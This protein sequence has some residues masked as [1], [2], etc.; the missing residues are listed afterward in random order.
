[1]VIRAR[2]ADDVA[3]RIAEALDADLVDE[4]GDLPTAIEQCLRALDGRTQALAALEIHA[5][6]DD[7]AA[8]GA[9][10]ISDV[11]RLRRLVGRI[12]QAEAL[13]E[14]TH[15]VL[16]ERVGSSTGVALHPEALRAAA[17][18]VAAARAAVV[19]LA[20]E[21]GKVEEDLRST[22]D[23]PSMSAL[24]SDGRVVEPDW[25]DDERREA[26]RAVGVFGGALV[27][28]I[29]ALVVLGT[30]VGLLLPVVA[31]VWIGVVF[32]R[33]RS[34]LDDLDV[35]AENLASVT[36]LTDQA[37]GGAV[38]GRTSPELEDLRDQMGKALDR[39]RY[40]DSA[41]VGLVGPDVGIETIDDLL[42]AR[43]PQYDVSDVVLSQTP[44]ARAAQAHVR[45]LTAQWKLAWY[46]LDRPVP[47]L[48][49]AGDGAR[50]LGRGG[51]RPHHGP[52]LRSPV[53]RSVGRRRG[54]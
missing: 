5:R 26:M 30:P 12:A 1:M 39:Q 28:S 27:V 45:R 37:Y 17:S 47:P 24:D 31:A 43:N 4:P 52:V 51:H 33:H 9:I 36:A 54:L 15:E 48:V 41:W 8:N 38:G 50:W 32:A 10:V 23:D 13:V 21:I 49:R 3:L 40:A 2:D 46:A 16:R 20:T 11:D 44:T 34:D 35:A 25:G 53:A 29:L 6:L 42:A 22:R 14:S 7:A 19:A 18:D